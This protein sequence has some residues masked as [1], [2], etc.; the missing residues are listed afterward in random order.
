M[1]VCVMYDDEDE[2]VVCRIVAQLVSRLDSSSL[3]FLSVWGMAGWLVVAADD[4]CCLPC[5]M[6]ASFFVG[7]TV[8]SK[9]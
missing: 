8:L 9:R 4:L 2:L 7:T 5:G 3:N 6:V 1:C